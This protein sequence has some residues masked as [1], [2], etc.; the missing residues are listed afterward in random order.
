MTKDS[1][2]EAIVKAIIEMGDAL[3]L[4]TLAESVENLDQY[5]MFSVHDKN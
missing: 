5:E 3:G 4:M 1:D 2:D